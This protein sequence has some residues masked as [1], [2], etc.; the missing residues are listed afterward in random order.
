[1]DL[2]PDLAKEDRD[3]EKCKVE[4][5][6]VFG[7]FPKEVLVGMEPALEKGTKGLGGVMGSDL[8][9]E[10]IGSTSEGSHAGWIDFT[11][12]SK[13]WAEWGLRACLHH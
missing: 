13:D 11:V 12:V 5:D 3:E 4:E 6:L 10:K 9:L 1:M 8:L 2:D 7:A